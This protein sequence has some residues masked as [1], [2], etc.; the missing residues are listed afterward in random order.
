[1]VCIPKSTRA[2]ETAD[3]RFAGRPKSADLDSEV[4]VP[5][6]RYYNPG[7]GRWVNRDPI[8]EDGGWNVYSFVSNGPER[9]FDPFGLVDTSGVDP[10]DA[11]DL[12]VQ[13]RILSGVEGETGLNGQTGLSA[14]EASASSTLISCSCTG[15]LPLPAPGSSVSFEVK[16][17]VRMRL[18]AVIND[19]RGGGP[20]GEA[21]MKGAY[22]HEQRHAQNLLSHVFGTVVPAL[23]AFEGYYT[24]CPSAR[25][26]RLKSS[27]VNGFI[28]YLRSEANHDHAPFRK[29]SSGSLLTRYFP[30]LPGTPRTIL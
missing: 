9:R 19:Q 11:K 18:S 21:M 15:P 3:R 13:I 7:L 29:D 10:A 25:Y 24:C 14:M 20:A 16:C 4:Y 30:H 27:L 23:A 17:S 28:R 22:G 2:P 26:R 1:M 6:F 12:P 8:G 5:G